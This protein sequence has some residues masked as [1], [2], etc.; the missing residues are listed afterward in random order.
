MKAAEENDAGN[1]QDDASTSRRRRH[2]AVTNRALSMRSPVEDKRGIAQAHGEDTTQF[3]DRRAER[4]SPWIR[5]SSK[6]A[7]P[8]HH[9]RVPQ[10]GHAG[11]TPRAPQCD[12]KPDVKSTS[13]NVVAGDHGSRPQTGEGA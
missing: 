13:A 2:G 6:R 8:L 7:V 11:D 4:S 12:A 9:R 5:P 1:R 3:P 10:R